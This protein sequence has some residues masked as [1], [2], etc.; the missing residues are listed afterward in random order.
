MRTKSIENLQAG[1]QIRQNEKL[2][3]TFKKGRQV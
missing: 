3:M 2:N 1:K